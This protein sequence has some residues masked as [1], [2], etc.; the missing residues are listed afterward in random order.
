VQATA[1]MVMMTAS[2]EMDLRLV[3]REA[4]ESGA[5]PKSSNQQNLTDYDSVLCKTKTTF[6]L[7]LFPNNRGASR[8]PGLDRS[9]LP[10]Q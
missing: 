9:V 6:I 2:C 1:V 8:G 7:V 10:A 3:G 5:R 4:V